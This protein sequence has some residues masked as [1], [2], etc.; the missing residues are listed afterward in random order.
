MDVKK[1][2]LGGVAL[3][4]LAI[5]GVVMVGQLMSWYDELKKKEVAVGQVEQLANQLDKMTDGA[6]GYVKDENSQ[7]PDPWG[8]SLQVTYS[9]GEFLNRL[10]VSSA[11]PD[12]KFGTSDD[13]SCERRTGSI[14]KSVKDLTESAA[15]G[16]GKGLVEG[17]KE[18]I[19]K[20]D[21]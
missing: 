18:E 2:V 4:L 17:A 6:G 11:G 15:K 3:F 7:D 19:K 16:A 5:S 12:K 21:K 14:L 13:I 9:S 20:K 10:N 1:T 8:T